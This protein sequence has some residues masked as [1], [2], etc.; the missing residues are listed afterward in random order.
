MDVSDPAQKAR[1]IEK[2]TEKIKEWED[3]VM[4]HESL[5]KLAS[6]MQVPEAMLGISEISPS[7]KYASSAKL[8]PTSDAAQQFLETDVLIWLLQRDLPTEEFLKIAQKN[9]ELSM[10]VDSKCSNIYQIISNAFAGNKLLDSLSLLIECPDEETQKL[11]SSL[12]EKKIDKEH[13]K[14]LFICSLQRLLD[15]GWMKQRESIKCEIQTQHFS[16]EES[17]SLAKKF[18]ALQKNRPQVKL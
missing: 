2:I 14:E 6:L 10:F 9:L 15:H 11:V 7:H 3:P 17:L 4:I 16:E 18:D 13:A 8:N 5:K 12:M 1:L